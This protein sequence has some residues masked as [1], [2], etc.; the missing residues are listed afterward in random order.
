VSGVPNVSERGAQISSDGVGI[1]LRGMD[2]VHEDLGHR[3]AHDPKPYI[4]GGTR[5]RTFLRCFLRLPG[6]QVLETTSR[7]AQA[8]PDPV[9]PPLVVNVGHAR[10]I[11]VVGVV[12]V[13]AGPG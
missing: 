4:S 10:V 11:P 8:G 2:R 3:A 9:Q 5:D 13:A 7:V 6:R 1:A 12:A